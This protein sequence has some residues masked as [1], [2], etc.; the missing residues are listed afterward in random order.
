MVPKVWDNVD[1]FMLYHTYLR[2]L[3]DAM[4][5]YSLHV[6]CTLLS[7]TEANS[8]L[9]PIK[10]YNNF[11]QKSTGILSTFWKEKYAAAF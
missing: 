4:H 9:L 2:T 3:Q 5:M 11:I 1:L 10:Y 8:M 6:C 7:F